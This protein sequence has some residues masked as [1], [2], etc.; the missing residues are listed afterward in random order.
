M[1]DMSDSNDAQLIQ[2]KIEASQDIPE[3]LKV[4]IYAPFKTYFAGM[5]FSV[6][7]INDTGPFDVLP[8][9]H[10]FITLLNKGDITIRS[11]RWDQ[12]ISIDHGLMHVKDDMVTVFLD[13]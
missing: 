11:S 5:A 8:H 10:N 2:H 7:A 3:L 4:K 1:P 13:I 6:S 9:H 12:T